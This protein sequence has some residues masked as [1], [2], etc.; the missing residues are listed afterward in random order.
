M[1][2]VAELFSL[3]ALAQLL[4]MLFLLWRARR[5]ERW[6][7]VPLFFG[8]T[9]AGYLLIENT[10]LRQMP[11]LHLALHALPFLAPAAFWLFSKWLFDDDFRWRGWWWGLLAGV[12]AVFYLLFVQQKFKVFAPPHSVQI[13][14]G[15]LA[16][17]ISLGFVALALVEAARNRG[18]DLVP[19]RWRFRGVFIVATAALITVTA[20][21]EIA[22]KG[23]APPTSLA[24]LQKMGIAALTL[25][26][27]VNYLTFKPVF[28][29]GSIG[30][31]TV[32]A[33]VKSTAPAAQEPDVELLG[34][35]AELMEKRAFWRTEG[36]TIR[37][38]AEK[39]GVKEYRLRQ[40]INQHL[41]HR[42]FN[43]YLNGYRI[44]EACRLLADPAQRDLTVLEI[45]YQLG[46]ASLAPFN[47]AFRDQ[48]GSSPTEWRRAQLARG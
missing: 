47:K 42:N 32:S 28:F 38:L 31:P 39:M 27:A 14:F 36:L 21:V 19:T 8:A 29:P 10:L 48:T 22:L 4:V 43:D 25:V 11:L 2:S 30:V 16:Q 40:A 6:I 46:Y 1:V 24:I 3:I 15:L 13:L 35:L 12:V 33:A 37:L 9:I 26:F 17:L 41:G 44:R 20:L 18:S 45:C 5:G 23:N 7:G 34:Q